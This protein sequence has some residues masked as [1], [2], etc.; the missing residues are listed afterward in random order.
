MTDPVECVRQ[1]CLSFPEATE[2]VSHGEPSWFAG[3]GKQFAMFALH[4]HDDRVALWLAAGEGVQDSLVASDPA[5]FFK[6]PY[7]GSR[8]WL[9]VFLDVP[10]VD[11]H[12]LEDL[13]EDGF[14]QVATK[15]LIEQL[16]ISD[17][18]A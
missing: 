2:K 16:A 17:H 7:V 15:K 9:G 14:R 3:R 6:P 5:H 4:H 12:Q 18:E 11:W 1:I 10:S 8:G 13:L